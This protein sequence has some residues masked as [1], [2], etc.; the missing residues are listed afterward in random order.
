VACIAAGF[1]YINRSGELEIVGFDDSSDYALTTT[2][3]KTLESREEY[4]AFNS[5]TAESYDTRAETRVEV[6]ALT[7]NK[8][9][10][11]LIK[12]NP[13]IGSTEIATILAGMLTALGGLAFDSARLD[14]QGDPTVTLGDVLGVTGKGS[15]TYVVPVYKQTLNFDSGFGMSSENDIGTI[16]RKSSNLLRLFTSSGRLNSLALEGNI[17]IRAGE[18]LHLAAGGVFTIDSENF[19]IDEDGNVTITGTITAKDGSIGG[20]TIGDTTIYSDD[21]IL[22]SKN[23]KLTLKNLVLQNDTIITGWGS[24]RMSE[25]HGFAVSADEFFVYIDDDTST[26][27][28]GLCLALDYNEFTIVPDA[29]FAADV[30]AL[31]FTDRP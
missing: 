10:S 8:H 4:G 15:K 17:K 31:T 26:D 23:N 9:N 25:G 13:L 28:R 6:S 21:L 29:Y 18:N 5:V 30:S 2:R 22:D 11:I 19:A 16:T 14:W 24:I 7:D 12:G 3:Y 1:A 27:N 20:F